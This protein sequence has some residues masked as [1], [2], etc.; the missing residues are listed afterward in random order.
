MVYFPGKCCNKYADSW[1]PLVVV[2]NRKATTMAFPCV[3]VGIVDE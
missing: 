2:N 3:V 1:T